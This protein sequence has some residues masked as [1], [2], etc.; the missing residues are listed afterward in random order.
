MQTKDMIKPGTKSPYFKTTTFGHELSE[1]I[2]VL[3]KNIDKI[4]GPESTAAN[5][6]ATVNKI[7][8]KKQN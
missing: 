7:N 1:L 2:V 8:H 4:K 5:R 6:Q 3:Q